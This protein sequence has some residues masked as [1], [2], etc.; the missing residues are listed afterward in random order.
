MTVKFGRWDSVHVQSSN[1]YES[2]LLQALAVQITDSEFQM[3]CSYSCAREKERKEEV[4][5]PKEE[6]KSEKKKKK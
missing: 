3:R 6:K 5:W 2:Q 4:T 1:V